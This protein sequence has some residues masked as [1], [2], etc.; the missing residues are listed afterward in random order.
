MAARYFSTFFTKHPPHF[1]L[2]FT[3]KTFFT[4]LQKN[5]PLFSTFFYKKPLIFHFFKKN[6]PIFHFF[7]KPPHFISCLQ[8]CSVYSTMCRAGP[9]RVWQLTT[10]SLANGWVVWLVVG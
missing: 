1:P 9:V 10:I 3:K 7:Y 2:F 6:T 8:A 4:F 5:T